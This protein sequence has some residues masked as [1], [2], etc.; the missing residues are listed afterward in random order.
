MPVSFFCLIEKGFF[1]LKLLFTEMIQTKQDNFSF[2]EKEK[3][4]NS[5]HSKKSFQK[6]KYPKLILK[7]YHLSSIWGST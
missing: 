5:T 3:D 7:I 4:C 2:P 6:H 1:S